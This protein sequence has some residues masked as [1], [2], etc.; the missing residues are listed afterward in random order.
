[1]SNREQEWKDAAEQSEQMQKDAKIAQLKGALSLAERQA[2]ELKIKLGDALEVRDLLRSSARALQ[3]VPIPQATVQLKGKTESSVIALW[4]DLQT[5]EVINAKETEGFGVYN[6]A[7]AEARTLRYAR[8]VAKHIATY[9]KSYTINRID[10]F[11]LGD[12]ISGDLHYE[13]TATNEVPP[14]VQ[15]I[16]AGRLTAMLLQNLANVCHEVHFHGIHGSNHS[17]LTKKFQFKAGTLN[18]YDLVATEYAAALLANQRNVKVHVYPAKKQLVKIGKF[19]FLCAHGDH[20]KSFMGI[21]WYA[22]ERDIGRE[23]TKRQS[24]MRN[25]I[26]KGETPDGGFDYV[27]GAHFHTPFVGPNFRFIVNGSLTGTTEFDASAG[28]H[29]EPQQ[30]TALLSQNHGLH[31]INNWR[32]DAPEDMELVNQNVMQNIMQGVLVSGGQE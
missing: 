23:S 32:L 20:L 25:Q 29:A 3:S 19:N 11:G 1:M 2:K 8:G 28:R 31:S 9:R 6:Y 13:L 30:I 14:P 18:S 17:R 16:L 10:V 7:I 21:P 26:R 15:A 22:F 5:G 4:S 12:M 24:K 27:L